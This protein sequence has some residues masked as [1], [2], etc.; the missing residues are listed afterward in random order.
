MLDDNFKQATKA[1]EAHQKN[2]A[3]VIDD[4][5][6]SQDDVYK[7]LGAKIDKLGAQAE[8]CGL[9]MFISGQLHSLL[10]PTAAAVHLSKHQQSMCVPSCACLCHK[11]QEFS[12]PKIFDGLIGSLLLGYTGVPLVT[13]KCTKES[14]KFRATYAIRL[15]FQFPFWLLSYAVTVS[16]YSHYGK[17]T[18]GLSI[19]RIRPHSS[20]VFALAESGNITG[21]KYAFDHGLASPCDVSAQTGDQPLHV[22]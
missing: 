22:R 8:E 13:K 14:C 4:V 7:R 9:N 10:P 1:F 17:P 19:T 3:L 11:W 15:H 16:A 6:R 20:E 5:R 12:S 21:L 18:A 2:S